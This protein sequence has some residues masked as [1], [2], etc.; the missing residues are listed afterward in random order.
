MMSNSSKAIPSMVRV[1]PP[2]RSG[3]GLGW[4]M[5]VV[6][7]AL[8]AESADQQVATNDLEAAPALSRREPG[9][10]VAVAPAVGAGRSVACG[11]GEV[12]RGPAVSAGAVDLEPSEGCRFWLGQV[13]AG[14]VPEVVDREDGVD[15]VV[16]V[17]KGVV[18]VAASFVARIGPPALLHL[19][20]CG[21]QIA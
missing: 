17:P 12:G 6:L 21:S 4:R 9:L 2:P 18:V 16:V 7:P 19:N 14:G 20:L 5:R 15:P 3:M 8:V 13:Q 10:A 1:D 11:A